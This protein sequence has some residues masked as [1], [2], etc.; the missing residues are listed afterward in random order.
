MN[1]LQQFVEE[2][3]PKFPT[4]NDLAKAIGMTLSGFSRG[5]KTG[6]LNVENLLKLA[7]VSERPAPD[8]FRIAGKEEEL[9]AI[10]PLTKL[11][12]PRPLV[13]RATTQWGSG[14]A[15]YSWSRLKTAL[16]NAPEATI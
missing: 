13:H 5:I 16:Q 1:Q 9:L 15:P 12:Q 3:R 8:V 4:L 7:K 6:T 10:I 11:G 14:V 2:L